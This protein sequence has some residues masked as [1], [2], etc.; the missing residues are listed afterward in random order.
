IGDLP[1]ELQAKLLRVLQEGE[2]ERIGSPTTQKVDVRVI[3]ATNRDLRKAIADGSFRPDLYYRR[4]GVPIAGPPPPERRDDIPLLA[5]YFVSK[6]QGRLGKTIDRI[7]KSLMDALVTYGWPGNVRE[8]ENLIE[9]ALI[10]S[11]GTTL[12]MD[13]HLGE[14]GAVT[15]PVPRAGAPDSPRLDAAERAHI[16]G[17]LEDCRWKLKGKGNAA[18][19][20]GLKPRTLRFPMRKLGIEGG[21]VTSPSRAAVASS[22]IA[23]I[24]QLGDVWVSADPVRRPA[25]QR[26]AGSGPGP[27]RPPGGGASRRAAVARRARRR[28]SRARRPP[29]RPAPRPP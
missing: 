10:L 25:C 24:E 4:R 29:R 18:E 13:E 23:P 26:V 7:P 22:R 11:P 27:R 21:E 19:R 1:L 17:V 5:W 20:L 8:L 9:R 2:F 16:L 15:D 14:P 28:P 6:H 12:Q 3:A